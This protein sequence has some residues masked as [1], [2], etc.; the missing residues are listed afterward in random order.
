MFFNG[1]ILLNFDLESSF[2]LKMKGYFGKIMYIF[3]MLI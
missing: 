2:Y 1:K 3:E